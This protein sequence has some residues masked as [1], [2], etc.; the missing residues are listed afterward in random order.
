LIRPLIIGVS[1]Q[2]GSYLAESFIESGI[3]VF[4]TIRKNSF[5]LNPVMEKFRNLGDNK[6]EILQADL[7]DYLSLYKVISSVKPTHIFN[8]AD[9]DSVTWSSVIPNYS[10]STTVAG[11]LN[12]FEIVR[13]L[14]PEIRI[15]QPLSSNM[16][17]NTEQ[18]ILNESAE[19]RPI[20][21]YGVYKSACFHNIKMYREVHKL[22]ISAGIFFNHESP[23]RSVEY[24][25][26]KVTRGVAAIKLG[27]QNR[28]QLGDLS[29]EIDWGY[30]PEYMEVA[31]KIND[32]E[33]PD[34]YIICT[35]QVNKVS[36]FVETVF[37]IAGL[38]TEEHLEIT[39]KFL[40]KNPT[41]N[42]RGDNSKLKNNLHI[43][44]KIFLDEI[45]YKMYQADFE[46]LKSRK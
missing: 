43:Q 45:A 29:G 2:D 37:E 40:R 20:S 8:E 38:K 28:I 12:I 7:L 44:P 36:R 17:G 13:E 22:R 35:G 27:M 39:S 33:I 26:R 30:A 19:L 10:L 46:S 3:K 4:G 16:Y 1:G 42:L 24:L 31:R 9:Q 11:P 15:F 34:D 21:H 41:K 23:R 32:S 14:N 5:S 18:E 6:I 25:S